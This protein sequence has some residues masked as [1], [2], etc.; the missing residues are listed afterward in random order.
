M[1]QEKKEGGVVAGIED[2]EENKKGVGKRL[3][4][5]PHPFSIH[6]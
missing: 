6:V 4:E 2:L 3:G 5:S 1:L